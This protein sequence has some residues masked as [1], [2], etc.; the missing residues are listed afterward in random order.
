MLEKIV[1]RVS[2][3]IYTPDGTKIHG[4]FFSHIFWEFNWVKQF[5]IVQRT[6]DEVIVKII[7]DRKSKI[8]EDDLERMKKIILN[9]TGKM[10]IIVEMVDEIATTKAG[11]WKFI[12]REV[13]E[14]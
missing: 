5:Q 10:N 3:F 1:G 6:V 2:D 12:V 9:R 7:P 11:K 14:G 13:K 8:N 4:E